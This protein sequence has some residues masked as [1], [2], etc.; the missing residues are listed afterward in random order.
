M[1]ARLYKVKIWFVILS[2]L[3]GNIASLRC[4]EVEHL[5]I[6]SGWS[7]T[8]ESSVDEKILLGPW[9]RERADSIASRGIGTRSLGSWYVGTSG[10]EARGYSG[11]PIVTPTL[12]WWRYNLGFWFQTDPWPYKRF[13]EINLID[14]IVVLRQTLDGVRNRIILGERDPLL[15]PLPG[16]KCE[17]VEFTAMPLQYSISRDGGAEKQETSC[18]T[19]VDNLTVCVMCRTMPSASGMDIVGNNLLRLAPAGVKLMVYFRT[20]E[21]FFD[22]PEFPMIHVFVRDSRDF[23][24][25]SKK[26]ITPTR[27]WRKYSR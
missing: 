12:P 25:I 1:G 27:N 26:P 21:L 5:S 4:Q 18:S 15:I 23:P 22:V 10:N 16:N 7:V 14:G 2:A 17:I 6:R 3:I 9:L 20:D 13:A 8:V 19:C 11:K 24:S